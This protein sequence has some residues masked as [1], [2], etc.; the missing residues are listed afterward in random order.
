MTANLPHH[1]NP[2][3]VGRD[4]QLTLLH[5]SLL[6][7]HGQRNTAVITGIG[8]VGKSQL[9]SEYLYLHQYDFASIFWIDAGSEELI[10][11]GLENIAL[12]LLR[13]CKKRK[14]EG[15]DDALVAFK[16]AG[17]QERQNRAI[18]LVAKWLSCPGNTKWLL[19]FDGYDD[20]DNIDIQEYLPTIDVGHIIITSR[21]PEAGRLGSQM[22]L[23][24]FSMADGMMLLIRSARQT[25]NVKFMTNGE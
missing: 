13:E 1:R 20:I 25:D 24:L 4:E 3:F 12:V 5:E 22:A 7:K 14:I 2:F 9:A 6:Q 17:M 19:V 8:G 11:Q 16:E 23:D 21:R 10:R 18:E 15:I